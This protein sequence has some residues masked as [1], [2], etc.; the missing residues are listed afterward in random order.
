MKRSNNYSV[1]EEGRWFVV[2]KDHKPVTDKGDIH[3]KPFVVKWQNK[4]SAEKY[5]KELNKNFDGETIASLYL[6]R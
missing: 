4:E 5:I 6:V 3:Q 2:Y 1:K